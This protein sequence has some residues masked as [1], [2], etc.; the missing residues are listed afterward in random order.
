MRR[1]TYNSTMFIPAGKWFCFV[2]SICAEAERH[3]RLLGGLFGGLLVVGAVTPTG[4]FINTA[5]TAS[6]TFAASG[7][8]V[9]Y[10]SR[11]RGWVDED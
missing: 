4:G 11:W 5:A 8:G 6:A 3:R 7:G 10:V 9:G 1:D 2:D